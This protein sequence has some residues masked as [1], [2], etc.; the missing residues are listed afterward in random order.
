[1]RLFQD[2]P[3]P[4]LLGGLTAAAGGREIAARQEVASPLTS[5]SWDAGWRRRLADLRLGPAP[6]KQKARSI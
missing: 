1:M 6:A 2:W 3:G 5:C 4:L